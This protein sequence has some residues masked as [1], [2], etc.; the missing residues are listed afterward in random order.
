[1]S[2]ID[3]FESLSLEMQEQT[4][5]KL[6][7]VKI[8]RTTESNYIVKLNGRDCSYHRSS[9]DLGEALENMVNGIKQIIEQEDKSD[10]PG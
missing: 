2:I 9:R 1:M 8:L 4:A 3:M 6:V 5:T 10:G 7:T